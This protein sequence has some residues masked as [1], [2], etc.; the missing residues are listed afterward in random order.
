MNL[1]E[2]LWKRRHL[3]YLCRLRNIFPVAHT[4]LN[5]TNYSLHIS[6]LIFA[7]LTNT[8]SWGLLGQSCLILHLIISTLWHET[9]KRISY[10]AIHRRRQNQNI[11]RDN[12]ARTLWW[13]QAWDLLDF[14]LWDKILLFLSCI[15]FSIR[16]LSPYTKAC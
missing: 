4:F 3:F 13:S 1:K 7:V 10:I 16:F 9:Q 5:L 15:S 8:Y 6:I 14:H 12:G 2:K 11:S